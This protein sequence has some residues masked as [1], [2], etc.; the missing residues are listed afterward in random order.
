MYSLGS[1][2]PWSTEVQ[3]CGIAHLPTVGEMRQQY[4]EKDHLPGSPTHVPSGSTTSPLRQQCTPPS[5]PLPSSPIP[6]HGLRCGRPHISPSRLNAICKRAT[7]LGAAW[8]VA[9]WR[10]AHLDGERLQAVDC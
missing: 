8:T 6:K 5:V 1:A 2:A 3:W 7:R 4:A 10:G 9:I